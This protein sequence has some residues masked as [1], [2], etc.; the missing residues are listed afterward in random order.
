MI[1]IEALWR[2]WEHLRLAIA[3]GLSVWYRDHADPH[4]SV[5]MDPNGPFQVGDLLLDINLTRKGRPLPWLP[6]EN[7]WADVRTN[8]NASTLTPR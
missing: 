8:P 4:L 7:P 2:A 6:P 3:L 5:L 1:R